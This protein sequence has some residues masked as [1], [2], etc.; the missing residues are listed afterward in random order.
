MNVEKYGKTE[1]PNA[2]VI[3]KNAKSTSI[4]FFTPQS[5]SQQIG[6]MTRPKGYE[7][8]AHVHN[9]VERTI[10]QTQEVLVIRSGKC[11]VELFEGNIKF[12]SIVLEEGDTI[13][14]AHGGH[15]IEMITECQ[16][17]EVK[18]GPYAGDNDKSKIIVQ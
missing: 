13:L 6:L 18:Q 12:E 15:R 4:D 9:L 16:I 2:I 3:R 11:L 5:Y 10:L 1:E 14:L 17:L 7:V 8:P